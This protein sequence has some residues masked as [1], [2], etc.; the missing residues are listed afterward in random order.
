MEDTE[1]SL[2]VGSGLPEIR[3][4]GSCPGMARH[5]EKHWSRL[6]VCVCACVCVHVRVCVS[7]RLC[8]EGDRCTQREALGEE[9]AVAKI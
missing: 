1:L 9:E 2:V 3:G 7:A 5:R 6:C 8:V 4:V